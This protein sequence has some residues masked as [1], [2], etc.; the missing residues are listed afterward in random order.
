MPGAEATA[1]STI[2]DEP[3]FWGGPDPRALCSGLVF[4]VFGLLVLGFRL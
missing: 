2:H 3:D 1:Y 4:G